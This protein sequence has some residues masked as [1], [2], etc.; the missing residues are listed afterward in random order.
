MV[1]RSSCRGGRSGCRSLTAVSTTELMRTVTAGGRHAAVYAAAASVCRR[2]LTAWLAGLL[3]VCWQ[4]QQV[5]RAL[6]GFV[7]FGGG[8][9]G[10]PSWLLTLLLWVLLCLYV[11]QRTGYKLVVCIDT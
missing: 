5:G 1:L 3:L 2:F 4:L 7:L 11:H 10:H 8:R 6:L 9:Q